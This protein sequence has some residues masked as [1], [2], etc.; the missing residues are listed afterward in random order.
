MK[1]TLYM[2]NMTNLAPVRYESEG[3]AK[4]HRASCKKF[5]STE[6]FAKRQEKNKVFVRP[7]R[8]SQMST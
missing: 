5:T 4:R 1:P 8:R 3:E 2:G 6:L 7:K